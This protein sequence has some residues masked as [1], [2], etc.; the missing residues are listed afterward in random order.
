MVRG[1][2][3]TSEG[4]IFNV[5]PPDGVGIVF[6]LPLSA[7]KLLRTGRL[8]KKSSVRP[9]TMEVTGQPHALA[10]LSQQKCPPSN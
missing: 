3:G 7:R 2:L 9:R 4:N 1:H 5:R 6:E 10:A 8:V